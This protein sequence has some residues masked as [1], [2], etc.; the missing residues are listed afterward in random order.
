MQ[1]NLQFTSSNTHIPVVP[2]GNS[3]LTKTVKFSTITT[4]ANGDVERHENSS[5]TQKGATSNLQ[6]TS[7]DTRKSTVQFK[8]QMCYV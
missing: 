8:I 4:T 1:R 5:T 2:T 3:K 7:S 6:C